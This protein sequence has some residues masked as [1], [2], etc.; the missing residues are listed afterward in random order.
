MRSALMRLW[1]DEA[2]VT[3][4]EYILIAGLMSAALLTAFGGFEDSMD[5]LFEA[6][7]TKLDDSAQTISEGE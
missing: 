4:I 3:A 2:G 1:K 5:G 6:I 7:N